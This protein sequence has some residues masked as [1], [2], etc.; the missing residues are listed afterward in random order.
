MADQIPLGENARADETER[1]EGIREVAPD[2]AY[3]RALIANVIF[4]GA[5]SDRHWVLV[6]AGVMGTRSA[7]KDAA[8]VRFGRP[9][10][11][12]VLTHGHFDHVG[13]LEDLAA[14][15]DVPVFAHELERPYLTGIAAYPPADP[16][17]GGGLMAALS[18][19]YPTRPVNVSTRF[20]S[21]PPAGS[22]PNMPGW[23]WLHTP[24]H[25]PGHV[26]LFRERDRSLIVGDAFVTTR[27]ESVYATVVQAPELHGPPKYFTVDWE[28]ARQSVETLASLEPELVISG[29]GRSMHGAALR[30]ALHQLA[31]DFAA[32]AVPPTGRYVDQPA[33]VERGNVYLAP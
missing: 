15:W 30:A 29:H 3:L 14:E 27:P 16:S 24:G 22:L 23:R 31:R 4:V 19:L 12:I 32:V 5:P 7:I 18:S 6:D 26:S 11:A 2:L 9:P 28:A 17:V 33:S 20:H 10:A 25:A 1:P 21:L 8:G 13:V